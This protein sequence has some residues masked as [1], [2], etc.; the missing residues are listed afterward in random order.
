MYL[1]LIYLVASLSLLLTQTNTINL[2]FYHTIQYNTIQ[3]NTIQYNTIQYNTI[4]YNTIPYNT[5]QYLFKTRWF[6]HTNHSQLF[7]FNRTK[8]DIYRFSS[9]RRWIEDIFLTQYLF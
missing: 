1:H 5:I 9:L 4:Q 6:P 8:K 3:Y 2:T 7:T